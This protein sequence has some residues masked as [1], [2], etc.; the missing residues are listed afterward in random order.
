MLQDRPKLSMLSLTQILRLLLA[1]PLL[2]P[3][4]SDVI[5]LVDHLYVQLVQTI[6][7]YFF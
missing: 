7:A 2:I 6:S 5:Q 1:S 3:S 4:T